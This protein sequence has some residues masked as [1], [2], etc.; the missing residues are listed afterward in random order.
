MSRSLSNLELVANRHP[1]HIVALAIE[2]DRSYR[3]SNL[4]GV[5]CRVTIERRG[6]I[7]I[8]WGS[9]R[10]SILAANVIQ[11]SAGSGLD[12]YQPY[13]AARAALLRDAGD[14]A[15]AA[16]AYRRAIALTDTDPERRF[17]ERQLAAIS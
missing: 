12:E 15:A 17:L 5:G 4:L 14:H 16:D 1:V 11:S 3:S 8:V 9:N 2:H 10:R 6:L 7:W 13:H